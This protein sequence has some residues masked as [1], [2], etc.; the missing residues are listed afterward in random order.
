MKNVEKHFLVRF[1]QSEIARCFVPPVACF[2]ALDTKQ[3]WCKRNHNT[4]KIFFAPE[5][6]GLATIA[7]LWLHGIE[8]LESE[9]DSDTLS[10]SSDIFGGAVLT[11][12]AEHLGQTASQD[13]FAGNS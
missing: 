9:S 10:S 8:V 4:K 1:G 12:G 13:L 7:D 6:P 11:I 5:T 2:T 3:N